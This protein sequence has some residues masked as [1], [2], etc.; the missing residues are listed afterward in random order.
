MCIRD[1]F[2]HKIAISGGSLL[3]LKVLEK[4]AKEAPI[5]IGEIYQQGQTVAFN[6]HINR[7]E[8]K[9]QDP[10]GSVW[11]SVESDKIA[12]LHVILDSEVDWGEF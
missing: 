4:L 7:S 3:K 10:S 8:T 5:S 6:F 12:R 11:L 9:S 2:S 1:R